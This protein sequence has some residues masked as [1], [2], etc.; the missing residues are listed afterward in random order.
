MK[1]QIK[2]KNQRGFSL[3]EMLIVIAMIA[4]VAAVVIPHSVGYVANRDLKSA[5]RNIAG[6]IY[7]L[8]Q[9]AMSEDR[10]YQVTFNNGGNY[11]IEQCNTIGGTSCGGYTVIS[12]KSPTAFGSDISITSA[13]LVLQMQP[14]GIVSPASGGT[15]QIKNG[16]NSTA[17][18]TI[19]LT[20]RTNVTWTLI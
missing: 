4:V 17:T 19:S 20:G 14:R 7:D 16:R 10:W 6:D 15:V 12:T 9:R 1:M 2:S 18:I 11:T 5:A 3:I 13:N 8:K